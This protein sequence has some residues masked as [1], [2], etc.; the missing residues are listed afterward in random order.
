MTTSRRITIIGSGNM[1]G[2]LGTTWARAGHAVTFTHSRT[3]DRL[4][5]LAAS[6]GPSARVGEL[7]TAAR[8]GDI[9]MLSVPWDAVP[10]VL[11]TVG[12]L[13]GKVLITCVSALRPDFTGRTM[14]LPSSVDRSAAEL[15]AELAPGARVVE[16]FNTTF[17]EIIGA[18]QDFAPARPSV[19]YCGDDADA[20][21]LAASLIGDCGFDALDAG[22]LSSARTIET[23]ASVWVQTAVVVG[24]YP[25]AALSVLQ[26]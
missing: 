16:A 3:P 11:T 12:P 18:T 17:A 6:A 13:E 23:L 15:I 22:P 8:D 21:R 10:E 7:S 26:R 4:A 14:G 2:A 5:A 24:R 25:S 1:G 20:K 9:L 19:W